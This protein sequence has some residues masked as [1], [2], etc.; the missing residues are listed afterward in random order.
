MQEIPATDKPASL[1]QT[2]V[3]Y[4]EKLFVTLTPEANV[5]KLFVRI[6]RIL[7]LS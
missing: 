5:I 3:N 7:V 2:V 6:L 1:L 4:G